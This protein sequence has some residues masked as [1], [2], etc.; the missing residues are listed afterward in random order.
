VENRP[1]GENKIIATKSQQIPPHPV[2]AKETAIT[3]KPII[4]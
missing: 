1:T 3:R 4:I 2:Q